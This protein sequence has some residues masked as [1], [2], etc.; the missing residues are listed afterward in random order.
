MEGAK[1]RYGDPL[2]EG[3]QERFDYEMGVIK[4]TGYAGYF[5]ITQDF[6]RWARDNDIPV[7]PGSVATI[8]LVADAVLN[9]ELIVSSSNRLFLE[10]RLPRG[11]GLEGYSASWT[12]PANAPVL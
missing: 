11:T 5:L 10:R 8:D 3:Q 1:E 2:S 12:L 9:R 6:I 4:G 7:G